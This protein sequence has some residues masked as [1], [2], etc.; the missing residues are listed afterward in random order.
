[1]KFLL[2]VKT[3]SEIVPQEYLTVQY[4]NETDDVFI[5]M[6]VMPND[7]IWYT[8]N[9]DTIVNIGNYDDIV[10]NTYQNGEGRIK[11]NHTITSIPTNFFKGNEKLTSVVFPNSVTTLGS[12]TQSSIQIYGIFNGCTNL[13]NIE[14]PSNVTFM[15]KGTFSSCSSLTNIKIPNGV[16]IL[17]SRL[18]VSCS[19][20]TNITLP[21]S[22][23]SINTDTFSYCTSLSSIIYDGTKKQW[24]AITKNAEA[25]RTN[26]PRT[27][28]VKCLDGDFLLYD[29][30]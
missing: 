24:E 28:V 1:M 21:N 20:L 9:D 16:E 22:V 13:T 12:L 29:L 26:V 17:P 3:D 2:E 18:F 11:F 6:G 25:W 10:S 7:E 27:C 23:T 8:T 30:K 4:S 14:I 5:I 19:S 15:E